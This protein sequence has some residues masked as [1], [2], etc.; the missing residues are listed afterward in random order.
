MLS[1]P[2][3]HGIGNRRR[4]GGRCRLRLGRHGG[5]RRLR[6]PRRGILIGR[7]YRWLCPR[8]RT[9]FRRVNRRRGG[10]LPGDGTGCGG[11]RRRGR[12][13]SRGRWLR[14]GRRERAGGRRP[15]CCLTRLGR[16]SRRD[17]SRR[18]G[19]GR[20]G[21][22]RRPCHRTGLGRNSRRGGSHPRGRGRR[23][24]RRTGLGRNSRRGAS[25]RGGSRRGGSRR[26][27]RPGSRLRG[28]RRY[29]RRLPLAPGALH[30]AFRGRRNGS[31]PPVI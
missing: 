25:R 22:R 24:C 21:S 15:P 4:G 19:S 16:N 20:R 14:S 9:G 26:R 12:R 28:R 5:G 18:R 10:L 11:S 30:P 6:G 8:R 1:S 2:P 23:P 3:R 27:P 7:D 31:A 29:D 13:P 17:G